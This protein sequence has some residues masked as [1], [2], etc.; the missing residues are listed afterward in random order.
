M[1]SSLLALLR[2]PETLQPLRPATAEELA[3]VNR[4]E[5][6]SRSGKPVRPMVEAGLVREDGAILYPYREGIPTLLAGEGIALR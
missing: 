1:E 2:C 4:E 5:V 3:V 6:V